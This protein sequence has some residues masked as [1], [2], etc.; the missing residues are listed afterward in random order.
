MALEWQ[1]VCAEQRLLWVNTTI[2]M[3]FMRSRHDQGSL[4]S[5][6]KHG[7]NLSVINN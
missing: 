2:A 7:V 6:G 3:A 1:N 5:S 4:D